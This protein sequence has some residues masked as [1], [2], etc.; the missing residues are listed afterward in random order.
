MWTGAT[1]QDR[2]AVRRLA[3]K[4]GAQVALAATGDLDDYLEFREH[5]LWKVLSTGETSPVALW[6]ARLRAQPT[7]PAALSESVRIVVPN[8]RRLA[9]QLGRTLTRRELATAWA[10]RLGQGLRALKATVGRA[11]GRSRR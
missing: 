8:P 6:R 4:T 3:V 10:Q 1:P 2:A 9:F 11:T 5:E 7:V